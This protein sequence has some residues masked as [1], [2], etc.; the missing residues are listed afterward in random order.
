MRVS[1]CTRECLRYRTG[2]T[3]AEHGPDREGEAGDPAARVDGGIDLL[4]LELRRCL[5]PT[6]HCNRPL[7]GPKL[8]LVHHASL[9]SDV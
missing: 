2:S 5:L 6:T 7:P 4:V 1:L 8:M 9:M 3:E